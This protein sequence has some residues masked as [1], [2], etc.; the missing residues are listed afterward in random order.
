MPETSE[1]LLAALGEPERALVP[2]GSRG[3]GV[4]V[5]RIAP[6]FPKLD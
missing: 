3:G 6:L 1:R 5:E 4:A 2:F